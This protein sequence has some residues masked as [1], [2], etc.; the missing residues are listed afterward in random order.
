MAI[1]LQIV[2]VPDVIVCLSGCNSGGMQSGESTAL[3]W[4]MTVSD[5]QTPPREKKEKCMSESTKHL[6]MRCGERAF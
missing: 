2:H 3:I 5:S 4:Q 1:T 6:K